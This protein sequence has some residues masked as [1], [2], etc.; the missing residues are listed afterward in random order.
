MIKYTEK[1]MIQII[2]ELIFEIFDFL[3][4]LSWQKIKNILNEINFRLYLLN[5][6]Y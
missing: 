6:K 2:K 1:T 5:N 3:K 4:K